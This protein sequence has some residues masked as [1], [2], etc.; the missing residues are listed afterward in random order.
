MHKI[1]H[2]TQESGLKPC[3][4]YCI[5]ITSYTIVACHSNTTEYASTT[6][7]HSILVCHEVILQAHDWNSSADGDILP[8]W[9]HVER[10]VWMQ[11]WNHEKTCVV[12]YFVV[13]CAWLCVVVVA[14]QDA[15][16]VISGLDTISRILVICPIAIA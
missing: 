7:R 14:L 5:C 8:G 12:A 1:H 15:V 13:A 11:V 9:I 3:N 2:A 10:M 4:T 16:L 6:S